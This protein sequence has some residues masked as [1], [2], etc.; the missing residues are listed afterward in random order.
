[1]DEEEE[2]AEEVDG[3]RNETTGDLG[4]ELDKAMAMQAR[5]SAVQKAKL[6]KSKGKKPAWAYAS[7]EGQAQELEELEEDEL[8]DLLRFTQ[9]LDF[10]KYLEDMEVKTALVSLGVVWGV[11]CVRKFYNK[12]LL[13]THL[14]TTGESKGAH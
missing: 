3:T 13:I 6:D 5:L 10:D 8:E 12:T 2:E 9:E 4:D 14:N 7:K 11:I 1:M